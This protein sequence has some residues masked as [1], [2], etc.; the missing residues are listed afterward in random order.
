MKSH[1]E[2]KYTNNNP[3]YK[4]CNWVYN[5]SLRTN[6]AKVF[7]RS[8]FYRNWVVTNVIKLSQKN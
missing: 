2:S 3:P 5:D 6:V 7:N 1:P 4:D 8:N